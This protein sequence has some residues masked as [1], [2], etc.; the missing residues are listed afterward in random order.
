MKRFFRWL[1]VLTSIAGIGLLVVGSW[2][3]AKAVL[4]QVLIQHAWDVSREENK[5]VKPWPWM[6][7]WPVARLWVPKH[8]VSRIALNSVSGQAL[9]FGPGLQVS[10]GGNSS[11]SKVI[12][13]H[14][15]THFGFLKNLKAGDVIY[16][17]LQSETQK[18]E[19]SGTEVLDIRD[20]PVSIDKDDQLLLLTSYPF[21]TVAI[22]GPLRYAVTAIRQSS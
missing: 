2:I 12:A 18:F 8:G 22:N 13:G 7:T 11:K 6:D 3:P 16:L 17:E 5:T 10:S 21:S 1:T 15:D 20:G 14:N 9:A 4:A 19:V